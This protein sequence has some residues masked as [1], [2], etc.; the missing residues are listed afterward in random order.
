MGVG[1]LMWRFL[2][3]ARRARFHA[4]AYPVWA[5]MSPLHVDALWAPAAGAAP[6]PAYLRAV[7][8]GPLAPLVIALTTAAGALD[9]GISF[10]TA[11]FSRAE[12]DKMAA[13]LLERIDGLC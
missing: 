10:R 8:T 6:A 13:S 2:S 4:K 5:G 1:G 11:A 12:T 7:P 3:P 9:I